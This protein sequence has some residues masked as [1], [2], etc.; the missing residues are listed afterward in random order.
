MRAP[1]RARL[2][3]RVW[4]AV[5]VDTASKAR[6]R[7]ELDSRRPQN[8]SSVRSKYRVIGAI[9]LSVAV[10][11]WKVKRRHICYAITATNVAGRACER[12]EVD[13]DRRVAIRPRSTG[14][15]AVMVI[16]QW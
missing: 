2:A 15:G 9:K 16:A 1:T 10:G 8:R 13:P 12:A 5:A 3:L 11:S 4:N 7:N 14:D 6:R